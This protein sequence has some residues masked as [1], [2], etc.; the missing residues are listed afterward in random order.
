MS[1]ITEKVRAEEVLRREHDELEVMVLE[2]TA[3]LTE[4]NEALRAEI[5]QRKQ[6]EQAELLMTQFIS[7]V[8][9]E[10]RTPLSVISLVSGNLDTLYE[11]LGD[12]RRR[13]MI[14][15]VREHTR[16]LNDLIGSVLEISRIDGGRVSM[17]R[18]RV[19]LVQLAREEVQTQL[20]LAQRKMQTLSVTGIERLDVWGNE[21]QL[22]RVIRNLLNNAIKYT[23]DAG[24][25]SCEC[26]VWAG[27]LGAGGRWPGTDNLP[28][29]R[30]AALRVV[31]T[32]LGMGEED[33]KHV[34]E[35]FFRVDSQT[36]VPGTG[37]GLSIAKELIRLHKGHIVASSTPG[38]GSVFAIYLPLLEE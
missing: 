2:R 37:L 14:Q 5:A 6:A 21:A 26:A 31:D 32:G 19:D 30:W 3:E 18:Q 38:Q 36:S 9:H 20:P 28:I 13:R 25:I 15:D 34:F 8:S 12:D 35:R 4:T 17:E 10:L 24:E 7:N 23:P 29:G 33:L 11:R 16:V 27:G 22:R 1:E